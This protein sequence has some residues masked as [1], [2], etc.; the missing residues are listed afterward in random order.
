[1][2]R[3]ASIPSILAIK[4]AYAGTPYFHDTF[5]ETMIDVWKAFSFSSVKKE[6]RAE[7]YHEGRSRTKGCWHR[8]GESLPLAVQ[9]CPPFI[10][11][12]L[13][14]ASSLSLATTKHATDYLWA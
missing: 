1:M 12:S 13:A 3:L 4:A 7:G 8:E 10:V 9:L 5:L 11:N 14:G 2:P 6:N